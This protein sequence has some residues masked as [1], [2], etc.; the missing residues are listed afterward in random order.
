MVFLLLHKWESSCIVIGLLQFWFVTNKKNNFQTLS[1]TVAEVTKKK[2]VMSNVFVALFNDEFLIT[3]SCNDRYN[4]LSRGLVLSRLNIP[5]ALWIQGPFYWI[6]SW[7]Y[8]I[9]KIY[10]I[11]ILYKLVNLIP[12]YSLRSVS[13]VTVSLSVM[14]ITMSSLRIFHNLSG[15]VLKNY[16]LYLWF[17]SGKKRGLDMT[18][19]KLSIKTN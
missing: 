7:C 11:I 13:C 19:K 15:K 6:Y 12:S 1:Q 5:A 4:W 2:S 8:K 18:W 17:Q 10:S 9:K 16:K 14:E 3:L